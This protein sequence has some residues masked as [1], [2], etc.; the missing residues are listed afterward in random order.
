MDSYGMFQSGP[1]STAAGRTF[2]PDPAALQLQLQNQPPNLPLQMGG[3]SQPN[4][5]ATLPNPASQPLVIGPEGGWGRARVAGSPDVPTILSTTTPT[6]AY[7]HP[8]LATSI[9]SGMTSSI[10]D[11]PFGIGGG[12]NAD[13]MRSTSTPLQPHPPLQSRDPG[14]S[15]PRANRRDISNTASSISAGKSAQGGGATGSSG[16]TNLSISRFPP[17]YQE[18]YQKCAVS[19]SG[20]VSTELLFPILTSSGLSRSVLKELWSTAN[21]AVPGKLS[22]TELCVLLGL[23]GLKQVS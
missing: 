9:A 2:T 11:Q 12:V 7:S 16:F 14:N 6:T 3:A 17:V 18:V 22:E 1:T 10:Q 4:S 20:F 13:R 5:Q 23:V 21:R 8:I 15:S 19:G